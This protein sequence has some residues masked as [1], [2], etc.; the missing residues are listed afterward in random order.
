MNQTARASGHF[1]PSLPFTFSLC[2]N[3]SVPGSA[4]AEGLNA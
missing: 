1:C 4:S 3:G 2:G